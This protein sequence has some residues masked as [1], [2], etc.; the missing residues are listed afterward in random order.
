MDEL[1]NIEY[2]GIGEGLPIP[3]RRDSWLNES[4]VSLSDDD[5][6]ILF[7]ALHSFLSLRTTNS[8]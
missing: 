2:K 3:C 6:E 7:D 5:W 8:Q 1:K 4:T